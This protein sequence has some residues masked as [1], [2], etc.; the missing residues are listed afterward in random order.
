MDPHSR[1]N[2]FNQRGPR[3]GP[4]PATRFSSET[5]HKPTLETFSSMPPPSASAAKKKPGSKPSALASALLIRRPIASNSRIKQNENYRKDMYLAFVNNAL[6]QKLN[7]NS[8]PFDELVNQFNPK[9]R[10]NPSSTDT[11][12]S[13]RTWILALTHV[14]SRLERTHSSLVEAVVNMPWTTLD[15]AT[16]KS[17]TVF[18]GM[19]LSA[20]PEYLS[21]I[22]G[23]IAQGFTYQSGLQT[24]SQAFPESSTSPVT[25]RVIYDRL[26]YLL[27]HL[28][29]LIPTLPST[30]QSLL[31]RNFPHKRQNQLAQSTYIRNLLRVSSYCPELSEKILATIVDRAIQI[32]VEIQVELEE[33]EEDENLEEQP[34]FEI[35]PFDVVLGQEEPESS[36][37]SD[38]D[39]SGEDD[40][41]DNFSDLSSDA[42]GGFDD[43]APPEMSTNVKHIQEM[44]NKLDSILT[45]V[46]EHFKRTHA[47]SSVNLTLGST[48]YNSASR[49]PSPPE[50]P[51]LPPLPPLA[52]DSPLMSPVTPSPTP[53]FP[54]K[55]TGRISTSEPPPSMH[56]TTTA[57][58][59]PQTL[60]N[61]MR[62][63]FNAL[64]SIFDR[65]IL[66]TF[67]SRYTQFLIFWYTSLDPEFSDV[68]QGMLVER[69]LLGSP[70]T[71]IQP[72]S[73]LLNEED[74]PTSGT[75]SAGGSMITRAAAA[76][77]I[78]SFV[79]RA[80]FVDSEGARRVVAIL[81]EF[82]RAHLDEVEDSIRIYSASVAVGGPQHTVF[83]AIAQAVFLIFCFRWRDLLD[84]GGEDEEGEG[85]VNSNG[86]IGQAEGAPKSRKWMP[87]LAVLQR[88]VNSV[89]NPLKV[90]S[91]NVVTQFA[92]VAQATD[93]I[94]CYTVLESNRRLEHTS[95][96]SNPNMASSSTSNQTTSTSSTTIFTLNKSDSGSVTAELNTFFPFDPYR[97]P[98]SSAFI[99]DVYR[100]WSSVAIDSESDDEEEEEGEE[101]GAEE[102]DYSL[103]GVPGS[104]PEK[105]LAIPQGQGKMR[106]SGLGH[107]E[108]GGEGGEKDDTAGGLGES[109]EQMSI[110]PRYGEGMASTSV[111]SVTMGFA[112]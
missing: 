36:D 1:L 25:R 101:E 47:I 69:A 65:T 23:K 60:F 89:L 87:E 30:L 17:Y 41:G 15:S 73:E 24:L 95:T 107:K 74:G 50:L 52:S 55:E 81:C 48:E 35:D 92:R 32:D 61:T 7:G 96:S 79:S 72:P 68:F 18:I 59:S 49:P 99:R 110:S 5:T 43:E 42:G 82:L 37:L 103:G 100:E 75:T 10:S 54:G 62:T 34:L 51:P 109:L 93:F 90:C 11:S 9:R 76:S 112:E 21:L 108:R 104:S 8:E 28:L 102:T 3:S 80:V 20:K 84:L 63:Q 105:Y 71:A 77:Y 33:L 2:Q 14:V 4:P 27:Q 46:F 94:Y 29:S 86:T 111:M 98:R 106:G 66:R 97:L 19:L 53:I 70:Q 22:L 56:P 6:Q 39:D 26:H 91:L 78:G 57:S 88:V 40:A 67:K 83:Y 45:L 58:S 16:V 13:L 38:V 64:L 85:V 31:V 12:T 44:V